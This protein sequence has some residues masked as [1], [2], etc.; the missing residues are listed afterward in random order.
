MTRK[1][2][3]GQNVPDQEEIEEI[4]RDEQIRLIQQSGILSM[5]QIASLQDEDSD[6]E[7]EAEG[8]EEE[9]VRPSQ[10]NEKPGLADEIFDTV[11]LL[12]PFASLYLA[13][14]MYVS[15]LL[16]PNAGFLP[17]P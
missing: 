11:I 1:R 2:R 5:D 8:E 6:D 13:M 16:S 7:R 10:L 14:N 12:I 3:N 17:L 15:T 9:G 4:P